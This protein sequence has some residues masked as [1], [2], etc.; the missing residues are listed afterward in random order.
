MRKH[1]KV[2]KAGKEAHKAHKARANFTP[3]WIPPVEP[4][5]DILR[6]T[7]IRL[8]MRNKSLDDVAVYGYDPDLFNDVSYETPSGKMKI[9]R[10]PRRVFW[11]GDPNARG[12]MAPTTRKVKSSLTKVSGASHTVYF[13]GKSGDATSADT[14]RTMR[15]TFALARMGFT[16]D[17]GNLSARQL[18]GLAR[19]VYAAQGQSWRRRIAKI[20][21]EA[22]FASADLGL[23]EATINHDRAFESAIK[24]KAREIPTLADLC[25]AIPTERRATVT[26]KANRK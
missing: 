12:G 11:I 8:G 2:S 26:R 9:V 5:F 3:A 18:A 4:A 20:I 16:D 1:S 13:P 21:R 22:R 10:D 15:E 25:K 23:T 14:L 7:G 17:A 24:G 19:S 6:G